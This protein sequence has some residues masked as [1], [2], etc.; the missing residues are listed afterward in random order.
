MKRLAVVLL[1]VASACSSTTST[2]RRTQS[3]ERSAEPSAAPAGTATAEPSARPVTVRPGSRAAPTDAPKQVRSYVA[4]PKGPTRGFGFTAKEIRIGVAY[5]STL[6]QSLGAAGVSAGGATVGDQKQQVLAITKDLNARG[7]IAGRTVVP[8]FYDTKGANSSN[9]ANQIAQAACTAW[10]ED[11]Q[12]FAAMTFVV[13][14]DNEILYSCLAKRR[15]LFVPLGG[16]SGGVFERYAPYLWSP[17]GV[18]I[19]R[20]PPTWI[21][22]LA[23]L[24]YFTGWDTSSG[25]PGPAPA[26]IGLLYGGGGRNNQR[27][28]DTAFIAATKAALREH[29]RSVAESF[30]ITNNAADASAAVLRFKSRGIT[31]VI[32]DYSVVN[33]AQIAESQGYRPRYGFTSFSPGTA[34]KLFAPPS[35]LRGALGVGWIPAGDVSAGQDPGDVSRAE[36]HC[37]DVMKRANQPTSSELAWF[38]MTWACDTFNFFDTFDVLTPEGVR[39]RAASMGSMPP[40]ATFK[41]AFPR[42]RPDGASVVRDLGYREGCSCFEYLSK[43][44]HAI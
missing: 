11:T 29:G 19:E 5:D 42:G 23:A 4:A 16:E 26:R 3:A 32:G 9:D 30:E 44:N 14:M 35:Q 37:R 13:Q 20:I 6:S 40:A 2:E 22:R 24:K 41:I 21:A 12:V 18:A 17:A 1:L 38:A 27:T 36:A 10:T 31:H 33:L 7:G 28:L 8:V 34:F 43:R 39:A 15:V 25:R